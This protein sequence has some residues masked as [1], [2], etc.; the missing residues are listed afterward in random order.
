[1]SLVRRLRQPRTIASIVIP[2]ALLALAVVALPGFHVDRAW[3]AITRANPWLVGGALLAY[4]AS[5]PIRGYRWRRLLSG[6]G[7]ETSNRD[8]TEILFLS[9]FVNCLVPAKLGD[10]YRAYLLRASSGRSLSGALGTILVERVLDLEVIAILGAI[11]GYMSFA[12]AMPPVV[13]V[14]LLIAALTAVALSVALFALRSFGAALVAKLPLPPSAAGMYE[15][16]ETAAFSSVRRGTLPQLVGLTVAIWVTEAAHLAL[17]VAALGFGDVHLGLDAIVFVALA[18]AL[19][20][21]VPLSPAGLGAVET[22]IVGILT[23]AYGVPAPEAVAI[24]VL[25]RAVTVL[26]L[27]VVGFVVYTL[28]GKTDRGLR[29]SVRGAPG[30]RRGRPDT[31]K[32]RIS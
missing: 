29:R 15:R 32:D 11:A 12:G 26:S 17:V 5:F 25:D 1:L 27:I 21:A 7:M 10:V 14:V 13:G 23:V 6:A 24:A 3:A 9:W 22:G 31:G 4:Y 30:S 16:F 2:V 20:T 8:A 28:S 18:G 19:L